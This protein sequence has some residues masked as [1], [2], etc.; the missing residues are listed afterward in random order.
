MASFAKDYV[1]GKEKEIEI[2]EK[3]KIKF[4]DNIVQIEDRYSKFDF[5]GDKYYY[6]LKSRN[7]TYNKFPSTIIPK[8]KIVCDNII[9]LF[10]FTDG[11]YY[12]RYSAKKFSAFECRPF[13]R[14]Q[15]TDYND[16][17]QLYYFIPIEKLKKII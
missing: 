3:L 10:N 9:F 17:E 8:S 6:E 4:N 11:L 16:I 12:I 5:K 13:K 14:I 1:F 15:R 2:L 7:N